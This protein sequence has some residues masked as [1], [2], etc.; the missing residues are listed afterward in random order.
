M[1][2]E[3]SSIKDVEQRIVGIKNEIASLGEMRTG[4]LTEQYN[5]CGNANCKCKDPEKPQKHG[6]YYQLSYTRY[7][8]STSQFVRSE[9]VEVVR[10]QLADYKIFMQLKD[11][12]IDCSIQLSKLRKALH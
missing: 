8:K 12:W 3:S 7:R 11:E 9:D 10:Q 6:P 2:T 4:S 5:V 1:L